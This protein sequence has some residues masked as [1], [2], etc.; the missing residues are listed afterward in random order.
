MLTVLSMLCRCLGWY[1]VW[2]LLLSMNADTN[3]PAVMLPCMGLL[4]GGSLLSSGCSRS[5]RLRL[6]S[7]KK[8]AFRLAVILVILSVL[9]CAA[10]CMLL[11]IHPVLS[12]LLS[13]ITVIGANRKNDSEPDQLF[14]VNAYA[15]FL[16]GTVISSVMLSIADLPAQRDLTLCTVGAVS[17][18]FFI[19][20]N[21]FM[22]RRFVRRRSGGNSEVPQEI[23][24][25]NLYLVLSIIILLTVLFAFHEPLIAVLK[26]IQEWMIAAV[27]GFF[28]LLNRIITALSGNTPPA[29]AAE[30]ILTEE[31]EMLPTGKTSPLWLLLWIPFIAVAYYVWRMFLSDWVYDFRI[32]LRRLAEKLLGNTQESNAVRSADDAYYDNESTVQREESSRHRQRAWRKALRKW[33]T[34]PDDRDKFYKGYRL[35]LDAPCWAPHPLKPADTVLEIRKKWAAYYQPSDAL[36]AVTAD[37]HS[38]RYAENNLPPDAIS[39]IA[40]ALA[41]IRHTG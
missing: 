30:D 29:E 2:L 33:N 17:A 16:S 14:N 23:R 20:R 26:Q 25:S 28:R 32:F 12:V 36:N 24:R 22:L 38:D 9:F 39:D 37:F 11:G 21:Q 15:A 7:R 13:G 18:I 31:P 4:F 41:C 8:T 40:A 19:L 35:L 5:L 1:P 34:L 6:I 3:A 10:G 27:T